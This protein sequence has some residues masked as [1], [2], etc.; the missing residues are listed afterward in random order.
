MCVSAYSKT[1]PMYMV[2][3]KTSTNCYKVTWTQ[4]ITNLCYRLQ[5]QCKE[6]LNPIISVCIQ[7]LTS[8][9][10][11]QINNCTNIK[12]RINEECIKKYIIF[13]LL[14]LNGF[15]H[16]YYAYFLK[17]RILFIVAFVTVILV[18]FLARL[19]SRCFFMISIVRELVRIGRLGCFTTVSPCITTASLHFSTFSMFLFI[20]L[21]C[22]LLVIRI[23]SILF[24]HFCFCYY[25][26]VIL[27]FD[28]YSYFL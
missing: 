24:S 8:I 5:H 28:C 11:P 19:C 3:N 9:I 12:Q 23:L 14:S 26:Y 13:K 16:Y 7:E 25:C 1:I 10:D 4:Q 15:F 6:K 20:N 17:S 22:I 18:F 27:I 21:W 2:A